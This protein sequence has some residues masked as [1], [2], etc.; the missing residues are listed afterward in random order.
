M[1]EKR[2]S[3]LGTSVRKHGA[4]K[5]DGHWHEMDQQAKDLTLTREQEAGDEDHCQGTA[6]QQ[7]PSRRVESKRTA[8][9]GRPHGGDEKNPD[10]IAVCLIESALV[11]AAQRQT[12]TSVLR[13]I[14]RLVVVAHQARRDGEGHDRRDEG[15]AKDGQV[16]DLDEASADH[17]G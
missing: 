11:K 7:M 14:A 5:S 1:R 3:D 10:T 13:W 6:S 4:H 12:H 2:V 9:R 16:E 15:Q 17:G 8:G